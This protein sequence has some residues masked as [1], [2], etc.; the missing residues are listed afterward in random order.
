MATGGLPPSGIF[1]VADGDW[2]RSALQFHG[3]QDLTAGD[4][5]TVSVP[6]AQ[7]DLTAL[8]VRWP[9]VVHASNVVLL[10]AGP[11]TGA[12]HRSAACKDTLMTA[13]DSRHGSM[14]WETENMKTH[15]Y[16]HEQRSEN[17]LK[18]AK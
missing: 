5:T 12:S 1:T 18:L 10:H 15:T 8:T 16:I 9:F 6:S 2:H 13:D 4:M 11:A 17:S 14:P 7:S 3:D